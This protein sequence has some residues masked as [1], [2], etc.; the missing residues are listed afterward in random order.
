MNLEK[1]QN[2][3]HRFR[4]IMEHCHQELGLTFENFPRGCCGDVAELLA[5]YLKDEDLG[6]FAYVSG[7]S[8]EENSSHAWLEKDGYI[9]DA[10]ADQ[11]QDRDNCSMVTENKKWHARF[12]DHA[13][14]RDDGDFRLREDAGH[15]WEPYDQLRKYCDRKTD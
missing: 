5:A 10:T 13:K 6:E 7:W 12:A 3:V 1:V 8:A 14:R 4:S 9:I 11:F 2:S 15:L